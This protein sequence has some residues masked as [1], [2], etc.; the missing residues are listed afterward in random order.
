MTETETP[1][2]T[3]A[4]QEKI[5]VTF[6][7]GSVICYKRVIDTFIET[8]RRIGPDRVA[9]LGMEVRHHPLVSKEKIALFKDNSKPVDEEWFV[10]TESD[11]AQKYMQLASISKQLDLGL[12]IEKA[13]SFKA[14][15]KS[16]P[17][18]RKPKSHLTVSFPDGEIFSDAVPRDTYLKAIVKIGPERLAQKGLECLGRQIV[19]RFQK[20]PNLQIQVDRNHWVTIY[21]TT[22][23]KVKVLDYIKSR[24]G[25][26]LTCS[27][28]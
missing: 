11:T 16:Q 1:V 27:M 13:E 14:Y 17:K 26:E 2:Q 8:I 6:P 7:D 4:K 25:V 15:D 28:E 21:S 5:Q 22:A 24:L 9:S 23:E 10:I 12:I 19:S 20:Y 3:R 18:G